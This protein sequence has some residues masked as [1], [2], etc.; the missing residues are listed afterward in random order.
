MA[1]VKIGNAYYNDKYY[2]AKALAS[3]K[4]TSTF[5]DQAQKLQKE[6]AKASSTKQILKETF[7]PLN[8]LKAAKALF[9]E[10]PSRLGVG[11]VQEVGS[12]NIPVLSSAARKIAPQTFTPT[13]GAE[14]F[15]LGNQDVRSL[16]TQGGELLSGFGAGEQTVERFGLP[17]GIAALAL[18]VTGISKSAKSFGTAAKELAVLKDVSKISK[19]LKPLGLSGERIASL[20]PKL[21]N[22][23]D[24]S[25]IY[26]VLRTAKATDELELLIG[27][28]LTGEQ[29]LNLGK[30]V[31]MITRTSK[32][33]QEEDKLI[34]NAVKILK[35]T[36]AAAP[37]TVAK[38][39]VEPKSLE[40]PAPKQ[41]FE[42]A[43]DEMITRID[44][45]LKTPEKL[46]VETFGKL[47]ELGARIKKSPKDGEAVAEAK[48][49]FG[50]A[51]EKVVRKATGETEVQT[52]ARENYFND[53]T[54]GVAKLKNNEFA[55]SL[56]K[57]PEKAK[58]F[59]L[60]AKKTAPVKKTIGKR[61]VRKAKQTGKKVGKFQTK[62]K[63][64]VKL[65]EVFKRFRNKQETVENFRKAV[66]QY[67]SDL[68]IEEQRKIL[69]RVKFSEMRSGKTLAKII[70]SIDVARKN[71]AVRKEQQKLSTEV[72]KIWKD[73]KDRG[74]TNQALVK[75]I[76]EAGIRS[77]DGFKTATVEQL[78]K[79]KELLSSFNNKGTPNVDYT[80][81]FKEFTPAK[82]TKDTRSFMDTVRNI[83][84]VTSTNIRR[85]APKLTEA[86]KGGV[87]GYF[88]DIAKSTKPAIET[89]T[90]Y[91]KASKKLRKNSEDYN[92]FSYALFNRDTATA[93]AI[94][95]QYGFD[96]ELSFARG[97]LAD[98]LD[99]AK[100]AKLKVGNLTGYWP[101]MV[102]DYEGLSA[103][104]S[105]KYGTKAKDAIEKAIDKRAAEL[106]KSA[107]QLTDIEK[108]D[109]ISNVLRGYGDK[110]NVGSFSKG[111]QLNDLPKEFL[112]YYLNPEESF[113]RYVEVANKKIA[114]KNFL[115]TASDVSEDTLGAVAKQYSL[116]Q[117]EIQ[118][119]RN[120]LSSIF[121]QAGPMNKVLATIKDTTYLTL[122]GGVSN[123]LT[124][125]LD[126]VSS[127]YRNGIFRTLQAFASKRNFSRDQF[128]QDITHE[129]AEKSFLS[130]TVETT[131]KA[132]GF[133]KIDK[134]MSGNFLNAA[135]LKYSSLAKSGRGNMV[136]S[137]ILS[138]G[139]KYDRMVE[140]ME[141]A[142]GPRYKQVL[143]D[144]ADKK[145][146]D[147]VEFFIFSDY[148]DVS[149]RVLS[150]MPQAYSKHP[151]ARI[152]Y[153][154]KSW[155]LKM[156]DVIRQD[157]VQQFKKN[158]YQSMKNFVKLT[159]L[160]S[161]SGATMGEVKEW[162]FNRKE[163]S[164]SDKVVSNFLSIFLLSKYDFS[165]IGKDGI[166]SF[167]AGKIL[168]PLRVGEDILN[169][170][171]KLNSDDEFY[172]DTVRNIPFIGDFWYSQG[173]G[174]NKTE[175]AEKKAARNPS[176]IVDELAKL[177]AKE[178]NARFNQMKKD[179][180]YLAARVKS[181]VKDRELGITKK[182]KDMRNMNVYDGERAKALIKY[183]NTKK[184]AEEKNA[185]YQRLKK[186]GIISDKVARQMKEL[187]K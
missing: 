104:I 83:L 57:N 184:T 77:R 118:S 142:F 17:A 28:S 25:I 82:K 100:K 23:T 172:S 39:P 72:R 37:K 41:V 75:A 1:M 145:I 19:A 169:D 43:R 113:I 3:A 107:E 40:V 49:F 42:D 10:G 103:A 98:I 138:R 12:R 34:A 106:G 151:N 50:T 126:V 152:F 74:L 177:P 156:L 27:K 131:F 36:E 84:G 166:G 141:A 4:K 109:I 144:M 85:I 81:S 76:H 32:N 45:A 129:L 185:L 122:L 124:N 35:E 2:D 102:A 65:A 16:K 173:A 168:P 68:P 24:P 186:A 148:L 67:A 183:I 130:K 47:E 66:R 38:I 69:S 146:T 56:A 58:Q 178:A 123:T 154:L 94:A 70:A 114:M 96:K 110:I 159:A 143:Q 167:V 181:E 149:P 20:S 18:E 6:A 174:K 90:S 97:V 52:L 135:F 99:R 55:Q 133:E 62:Q 21:V 31:S 171:K 179:D 187:M 13:T 26:D 44:E 140:K 95:K 139:Y 160:I 155:S 92:K 46:S 116:S 91:V 93:E 115:G 136:T 157:T 48:A 137:K 9:V 170:I 150:E 134:I 176:T 132:T 22:A 54:D 128:F 119:L 182:E 29:T 8:L 105:K 125:M 15:L 63:A 121:L 11:A 33:T 88:Y 78:Q 71:V 153:V 180:P 80:G 158:P 59:Y 64:K 175:K 163:T 162:M 117:K 86:R 111:R 5:N 164:F 14:K 30:T 161:V 120:S 51:E 61:E 60:D 101:R 7:N 108:S 127:T 165:T 73:I 147:D 87:R 79:V 89:M 53:F 112:P